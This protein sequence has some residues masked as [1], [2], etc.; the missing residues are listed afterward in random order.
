MSIS[1]DILCLCYG[2][3]FVI[4]KSH[5]DKENQQKKF[6]INRNC[7]LDDENLIITACMS[8]QVCGG[9]NYVDWTCI[10]IGL[11]NGKIH[12]YSENGLLIYERDHNESILN[13]R[14]IGEELMVFYPS[15]IIVYQ[16][17]HLISLLKTLKEMLNKAKTTK[18]DLM[19]KDYMLAYKKWDYK[20]KEREL[21]ISDALMVPQYK[22]NLF[23]HLL[24]ESLE[25]GFTKKY[26]L[27][28]YQSSNVISCGAKPFLSFF[29][30]RE[31]FKQ[32]GVLQDV[33]K[34]M[35]NKI[36]SW[37]TLGTILPA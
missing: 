8:F 17:T 34:A 6:V 33:A 32:Q 23:D 26:R 7:Q 12:F 2:P 21:L 4:L 20:G 3:K 25:L 29:S 24:A 10:A 35:V 13:L 5:Y 1:N 16:T 15:C 27:T 31:G 11:S 36:T 19:D 18:I 30:A 22:T 28:P 14:L 37:L 9:S